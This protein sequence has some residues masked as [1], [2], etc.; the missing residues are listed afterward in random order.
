MDKNICEK[1]GNFLSLHLEVINN[2][3]TGNLFLICKKKGSG[4]CVFDSELD[5]KT[6]D[7]IFKEI[8]EIDSF[9][10]SVRELKNFSLINPHKDCEYY[11][12]QFIF[13][14]GGES[15]N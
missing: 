3:Y 1:C 5:R 12:E 13:Q 15:D 10:K 14:E 8:T 2:T 11:P 4:D 6:S 7:I 9:N